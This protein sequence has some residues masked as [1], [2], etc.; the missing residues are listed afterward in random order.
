MSGKDLSTR[1]KEQIT[2]LVCTPL[3][4]LSHFEVYACSKA[5]T[6]LVHEWHLPLHYAVGN[7]HATSING[8]Q[9]K[10]MR[11]HLPDCFANGS[12]EIYFLAQNKR[13]YHD[14]FLQLCKS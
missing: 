10:S 12:I 9:S 1:A 8:M 3:K 5:K 13:T 4:Q 7:V 2:S 14:P 6:I 11:K